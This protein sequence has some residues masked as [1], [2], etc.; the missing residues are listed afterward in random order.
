MR[1]CR[2]CVLACSLT[3]CRSPH[4]CHVYHHSSFYREA[5]DNIFVI[6]EILPASGTPVALSS[7]VLSSV[8]AKKVRLEEDDDT[9]SVYGSSLH[10]SPSASPA[11][12]DRSS[13]KR[14]ST[15]SS[16]NSN[17]KNKQVL[18]LSIVSLFMSP[19]F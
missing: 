19:G 10:S 1:L 4:A 8:P 6:L 13:L 14:H 16:S 15:S 17:Q 2:H 18:I 5:C 11:P 7:G 9:S 3:C 12:I